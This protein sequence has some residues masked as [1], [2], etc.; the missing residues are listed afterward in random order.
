[1]SIHHFSDKGPVLDGGTMIISE[2]MA[3]RVLQEIEKRYGLAGM[4]KLDLL[5]RQFLEPLAREEQKAHQQHQEEQE[6]GKSL[7]LALAPKQGE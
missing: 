4:T 5:A 2:H 1:M 3:R 7:R 6:V